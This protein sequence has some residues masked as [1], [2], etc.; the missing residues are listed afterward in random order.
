MPDDDDDNVT[1]L[2]QLEYEEEEGEEEEESSS[3]S[4]TMLQSSSVCHRHHSNMSHSHLIQLWET[5]L[6]RGHSLEIRPPPPIQFASESGMDK[7]KKKQVRF[8]VVDDDPM[9]H[10]RSTIDSQKEADLPIVQ[11]IVHLIPRN[12]EIHSE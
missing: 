12:D 5:S 7:L 1:M 6:R 4:S 9:I 8:A 2:F 11:T 10:G 3:L